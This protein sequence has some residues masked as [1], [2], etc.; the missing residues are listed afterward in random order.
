MKIVAF[1]LDEV[2]CT[3]EKQYECLGKD[4]YK[5][6]TPILSNIAI[7][8]D[9]YD[10]GFYIKIYTARGMSQFKGNYKTI[11][12]ELSNLTK[13]QLEAWGA[14]YNE[15]I[16][17]KTHY[18]ILIDDKVINIKEINSSEDIINFMDK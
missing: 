18:D 3:R 15:L 12:Q 5:Y 4:K 9:C 11:I 8:N 14:K 17:G 6:C 13:E 2:L 16:F 1:D 7:M 10:K